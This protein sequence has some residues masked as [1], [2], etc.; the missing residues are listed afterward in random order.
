MFAGDF[1]K[2]AASYAVAVAETNAAMG[3]IAACPTAGSCGIVSRGL[4]IAA[5]KS[6]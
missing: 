2:E 6:L 3:K 5:Q 4:L 1:V